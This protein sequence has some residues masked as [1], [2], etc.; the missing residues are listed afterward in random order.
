MY[1]P[2]PPSK[3]L[4]SETLYAAAPDETICLLAL[5]NSSS[6]RGGLFG[7]RPAAVRRGFKKYSTGTLML[8]GIDHCTPSVA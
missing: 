2:P 5:S 7:S 1:Q 3:S 4:S 8:N 6:E